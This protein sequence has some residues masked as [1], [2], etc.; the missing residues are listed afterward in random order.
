[1]LSLPEPA[2]AMFVADPS[3]ADIQVPSPREPS[4]TDEPR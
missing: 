1:M 4:S 2:S 3:I